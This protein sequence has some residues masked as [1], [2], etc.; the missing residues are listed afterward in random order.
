MNDL[1]TQ[2]SSTVLSLAVV[3]ALA[4][5]ALY[6]LKRL[7]LTR[8][9]KQRVAPLNELRFVR[10]LSVGSKERVVVLHYQGQEWLLGVAAGGVTLLAKQEIT[11]APNA[12]S[13]KST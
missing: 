8:L 11:A 12:D 4:F 3:G 10:A 2:L 9:G 13:S 7:Q 6:L 1:T 5:G